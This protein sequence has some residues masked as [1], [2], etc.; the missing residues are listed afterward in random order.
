MD[1]DESEFLDASMDF[2]YSMEFDEVFKAREKMIVVS[3]MEGVG[4]W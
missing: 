3:F 2:D 1:N 4:C